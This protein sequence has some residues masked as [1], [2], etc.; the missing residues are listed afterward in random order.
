[1]DLKIIF[2]TNQEAIKIIGEQRYNSTG[3]VGT[4]K[5]GAFQLVF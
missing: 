4:G 1:M 3:S 2:N 5:T